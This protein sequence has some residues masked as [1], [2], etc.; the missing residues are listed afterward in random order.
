[1]IQEQ[2]LNY[3]IQHKDIDLLNTYDEKF[4]PHN[5]KEFNF[6]KDH[7]RKYKTIPDIETVI[8][9]FD[10]F[11]AIDVTE[12]LDY[13]KAK[14][15]EEYVYNTALEVV[16]SAEELYTQDASMATNYII[17]NLLAIKP[18]SKKYG[19]DII[20]E[21]QS[22][23]DKLLDKLG[24]DRDRWLLS[25]GLPELDLVIDG[26]QRGEELVVIYART[27][28][29]KSWV[30]ELMATSVWKD[31]N[32]IGFFEPEM[33][34]DSVGYRFDTLY[35]NFDN[36]GVMGAKE[37]FDVD[38]YRSYIKKLPKNDK[39]FIVSNP[40]RFD[41]YTTVSKLRKWVEDDDLDMLVIDGIT[42]LADER[43]NNKE[44]LTNR[45]TNISEDLMSLSIE[46]K[47]PII[48][49]VQANRSAARDSDG[50]LASEAPELDTIRNSDGISHNASKALSVQKRDNTI[51]I[52]ITKNRTGEVHNKLIY[53]CDINTGKFTYLPNPKANLPLDENERIAEQNRESYSDSEAIF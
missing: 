36:K 44:S 52:K 25:T 10:E 21:A 22:R 26:L 16:N 4:F 1:M 19:I 48:V 8:D 34:E 7:Y 5:V 53:N 50:E 49:V 47:I 43:S 20:Q 29:C 32:N 45:L 12:S 24:D 9:K 46:K 28:N 13:L 38:K 15:Y 31:G 33:T 42:Y 51:V 41:N 11:V 3:I 6:I 18:P 35:K 37:D 14:L 40:A 30:A 39:K 2:F 27:N 23:Y 17:N